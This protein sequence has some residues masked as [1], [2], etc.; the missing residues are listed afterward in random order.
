[1]NQI[2]KETS[3][4]KGKVHYL[5]KN[6]KERL[7][8]SYIE[9]IREFSNLFKKSNISI[10]KCAQGFRIINLLKSFGIVEN[11]EF[12]ADKDGSY[13]GDGDGD[14]DG[15]SGDDHKDIGNHHYQ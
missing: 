13:N 4:S 1:M 7:E 12:Y 2:S 3:F 9:K 15:S 10:E 14:G 8:G 6:W 5:I 11:L